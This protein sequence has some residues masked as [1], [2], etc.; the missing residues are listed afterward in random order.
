M[1]AVAIRQRNKNKRKANRE[2]TV[3]GGGVAAAAALLAAAAAA[4]TGRTR[5][6]QVR[7]MGMPRS[8]TD[9][10]SEKTSPILSEVRSSQV[11]LP[12]L[13]FVVPTKE[14][15]SL[16]SALFAT[17]CRGEEKTPSRKLLTPRPVSLLFRSSSRSRAVESS[18]ATASTGGT[19][20]TSSRPPDHVVLSGAAP[21]SQ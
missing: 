6:S 16:T 17:N 14:E 7:E 10:R 15:A 21:W 2:E 3:A 1:L 12:R 18:L 4:V 5:R 11:C 13:S 9:V 20:F 8:S 19:T